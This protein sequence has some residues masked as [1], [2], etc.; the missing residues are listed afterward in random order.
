MRIEWKTS[1]KQGVWSIADFVQRLK[2]HSARAQN[3][4]I[5]WLAQ[6]FGKVRASPAHNVEQHR[7]CRFSQIG[8]D[9]LAFPEG[10]KYVSDCSFTMDWT[11][12]FGATRAPSAFGAVRNDTHHKQTKLNA[13]CRAVV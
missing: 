4:C 1:R 13:P 6:I 12:A 10:G 2:N 11:G 8:F 9:R 3:A 5:C 7:I